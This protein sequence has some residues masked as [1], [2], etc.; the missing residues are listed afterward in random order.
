MDLVLALDELEKTK[1][2]KKEE[3]LESIKGALCAAYVKNFGKDDGKGGFNN[4]EEENIDH[5]AEKV[6]VDIDPN[7]GKLEVYA[8]K[9]VVETVNDIASEISLDEATKI[10][11][12]YQLDDVVPVIVTPRNFN[13]IAAQHARSII[14]QNIKEGERK[15]NYI[16]FRSKEHEVVTGVVRRVEN[17]VFKDK[18]GNEVSSNRYVIGLDEKNEVALP[19]KECVA[20]EQFMVGERV[21]VYVV[22]VKDDKKGPRIIVSR[23]HRDLVKRLLEK[24]V[25]EIEDGTVE[26]KSIARDAGSR[27]KVSVWAKDPDVDAVGACVGMN[28]ARINAIVSDLKGEKI[29][30][31][32]WDP[33]PV[34]LVANSLSPSKVVDVKVCLEEKTAKVIVPDEQLS[35]AIG[36]KGQNASLAVRLTGYKI[37]I[38]SESQAEEL[39]EEEWTEGLEYIGKGEYL[40]YKA[41]DSDEDVEENVDNLEEVVETG[42]NTEFDDFEEISEDEF[43][44]FE[45]IE[46]ISDDELAEFD[47]EEIDDSDDE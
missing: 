45:E 4:R 11:S 38:K 43:E 13:R 28:G 31:I 17:H 7:T 33:D 21:K 46:E 20:G 1:G 42:E 14:I 27:T 3:I 37:D 39:S 23:T 47:F 16:A 18:K 5:K 6:S 19:E 32:N 8:Q 10:N 9:R 36:K 44:E 25:T 24:E 30:V 34:V 12:K 40:D 2:V 15:S 26:I 41:K 22:E 29:D 35:L